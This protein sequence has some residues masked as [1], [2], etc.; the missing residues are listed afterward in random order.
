MHAEIANC[1]HCESRAK[2]RHNT[3]TWG[4][5]RAAYVVC[6]SDD[7]HRGPEIRFDPSEPMPHMEAERLAVLV[8]NQ[9]QKG[10]E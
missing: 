4:D 3:D 9:M 10:I 7:A 6:R 2:V 5:P 1:R 8:W